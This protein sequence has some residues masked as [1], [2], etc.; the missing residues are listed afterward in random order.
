MSKKEVMEITISTN[1]EI[2]I[3]EQFL[4]D[5]TTCCLCGSDL[6]FTHVTKFVT[7]EVKEQGAC[8]SC[9]IEHAPKS[10]PLQ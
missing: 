4:L 7:G 5:Y 10:H 1:D 9:G 6:M 2:T 8:E 3:R